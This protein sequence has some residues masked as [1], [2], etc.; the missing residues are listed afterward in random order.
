[1]SL[2]KKLRGQNYDLIDGAVRSHRELQLWIDKA[3]DRPN[4]EKDH[5]SH[6]FKSDV[7]LT[8]S[9]SVA[10]TVNSTDTEAYKFNIGLTA[11]DK[12]LEALGLGGAK[13]SSVIKTGKSVEISYGNSTVVEYGEGYLR[14]YLAEAD[15]L[16]PNKPFLNHLD[17]NNILV[18]SGIVYAENLVAKIHTD[19]NVDGSIEAELKTLLNANIKVEASGS[20]DL[21]MTAEGLGK[22]PIAVKAHRLRYRR[23]KFI[24]LKLVTDH[25]NLF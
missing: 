9:E 7:K 12:I 6:A 2:E 23:G 14:D 13:I 16:H 19:F 25:N 20:S 11:L 21:T 3:F 15:F 8:P 4:L 18:L 10:L 24:D 22:M 5:I 1:M 17:R